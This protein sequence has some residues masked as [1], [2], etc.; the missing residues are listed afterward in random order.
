MTYIPEILTARIVDG[1]ILDDDVNAAHIDGTAGTP[2]MRTLGTGAQQALAGNT[3]LDA[4]T[5]PT[6]A[7]DMNSQ[8]FSN[9]PTATAA[10]QAV[11]FSQFDSAISGLDYK[12]AVDVATTANITLSGEQTI[13]GVLTSGS[14]VLVKNQ[15]TPADNGIYT[16]A[17]GAWTR[18]ADADSGDELDDGATVWVRSGSTNGDTRWT[19]T[20]PV[21]TV[22]GASQSW[23]QTGSATT[24]TSF[25]DLSDGQLSGPADGQMLRY[26]ASSGEIQ[27]T[28]NAVM[29]DAGKLQLPTTGSPG[30]LE[31]GGDWSIYRSALG[32]ATIP[33]ANLIVGNELTSGSRFI[34]NG[35]R[36]VDLTSVSGNTSLSPTNND[37]VAVDTSGGAVTITLPSA[38]NTGA[39]FEVKR[40][41]AN[42]VN[43]AATPNIDGSAS[44]FV[45]D[46]DYMAATFVFDGTEYLV[47]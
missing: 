23:A 17:A 28:A 40:V 37:F 45:L 35:G 26:E 38:P 7:V 1:T 31:I 22:G 6:S 8:Q 33:S 14:D 32:T 39:K 16:T 29:T 4:V 36:Q 12:D 41:G 10:G 46:V 11:E 42:N 15:S 5:S 13:D 25:S 47:F 43:V 9:L 18:R 3:T 21:P 2:S 44:D 27:N 24:V 20:S 30:G 34:S 19:Q